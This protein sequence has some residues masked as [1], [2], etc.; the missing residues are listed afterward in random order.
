MFD[1]VV[2]SIL[3]GENTDEETVHDLASLKQS[4]TQAE[5]HV[6]AFLDFYFKGKN[7]ESAP[8]A[9]GENKEILICG[10]F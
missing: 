8:D 6:I 9:V 1:C 5:R 3:S 4:V 7:V 10:K 2:Y